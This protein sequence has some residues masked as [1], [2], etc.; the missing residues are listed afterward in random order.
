MGKIEKNFCALATCVKKMAKGLLFNPKLYNPSVS[1][2]LDSSPCTG[3]P[4]V[5]GINRAVS[6]DMLHHLAL[7]V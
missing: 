2:S 6:I 4:S 1:A 7:P 3:E 5:D